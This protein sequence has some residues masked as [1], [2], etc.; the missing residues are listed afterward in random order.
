MR[1]WPQVLFFSGIKLAN[2][3]DHRIP[4]RWFGTRT[5]GRPSSEDDGD[6]AIGRPVQRCWRWRRALI[7]VVEYLVVDSTTC[8]PHF[9]VATVIVGRLRSRQYLKLQELMTTQPVV[10]PL[11]K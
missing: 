7:A 10:I 1:L 2:R 4:R 3:L 9:T 8:L 5:R 6:A 11:G